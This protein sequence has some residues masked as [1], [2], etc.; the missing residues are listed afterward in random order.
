MVR[1]HRPGHGVGDHVPPR[2]GRELRDRHR[3]V[4][5]N[6][7]GRDLPA[8]Q[9]PDRVHDEDAGAPAGHQEDP[10]DVRGR[11]RQDEHDDGP[12]V[13]GERAQPAGRVPAFAFTDSGLHRAVQGAAELGEGG[14]LGGVV[15]LDPEPRRARLRR[16]ERGLAL[17]VR[18]LERRRAAFGVVGHGRLFSITRAARRGAERVDAAP[19]AAGAERRSERARQQRG[20]QVFASDGW[21]LFAQ[22]A[23]GPDDLLV[24]QQFD[25]DGLHLIYSGHRRGQPGDDGRRVG[26]AAG[27][28]EAQEE[29][30]GE[31]RSRLRGPCRRRAQGGGGAAGAGAARRRRRCRCRRR[32]GG[33]GRRRCARGCCGRRRARGGGRGGRNLKERREEE[34]QSA[35]EVATE[36]EVAQVSG[37][38]RRPSARPSSPLGE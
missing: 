21:V 30:E 34:G 2:C 4:Y 28:Q 33:G 13:S 10:G 29:E 8:K 36:Q 23:G 26:R 27:A 16:A 12:I 5:T 25:H 1:R 15:P 6:I 38:A 19:G 11:S 9:G 35:E 31:S 17:Q 3:V 24:L 7:K 18:Q 14:P 32:G 20:A 37:A 22:R